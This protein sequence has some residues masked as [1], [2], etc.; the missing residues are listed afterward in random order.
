MKYLAK[1]FRK[2]RLQEVE[3]TETNLINGDY[4]W[5]VPIIEI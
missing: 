2:R 5:H 3:Y 4:E 1:E